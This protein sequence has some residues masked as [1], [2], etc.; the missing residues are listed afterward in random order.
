MIA[1]NA[2]Y[3]PSGNVD[4]KM[5]ICRCLVDC[6]R[7]SVDVVRLP[8]PPRRTRVD[9][10]ITEVV[11]QQVVVSVERRRV[12]RLAGR[13]LS[14]Q[15]QHVTADDDDDVIDRRTGKLRPAMTRGISRRR[16]YITVVLSSVS[17]RNSRRS[18]GAGITVAF[19]LLRR[20]W[21]GGV[22]CPAIVAAKHVW[23]VVPASL[24]RHFRN[25]YR[26]TSVKKYWR[27]RYPFL[28]RPFSVL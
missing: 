13:K 19:K 6:S 1:P 27:G 2:S 17:C 12:R 4:I 7:S 22:L 16:L 20:S 3:K 15:R 10:V 25:R 8:A 14:G 24:K 5:L 28:N 18:Y 23:T 21:C 9:D 26:Y 11:G